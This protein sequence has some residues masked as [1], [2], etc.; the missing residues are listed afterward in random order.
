M[1]NIYK[2][3]KEKIKQG[4]VYKRNLK[5]Y[6]RFRNFTMI[7]QQTYIKNLELAS[8][9]K[10]ISGCVVECGVW[11]G[12]MIAGISQVIGKNRNYYLFDSFQGL[13]PAKE[14]DGQAALS[15][16]KNVESPNYHKNCTASENEAI[17]A[18]KKAKVPS[19]YTRAGWFNKTLPDFRFPEPIGYLRLDADWYESTMI[20]L[21]ELF[22]KVSP[23]GLIVIDDYFTWDGCSRAVHDFL[24]K[25]SLRE[26][27]K[28][29]GDICYIEKSQK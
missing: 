25:H 2:K 19:F 23:R 4:K 12:G 16:Q 28:S 13:P 29:F 11:R 15:W 1:I 17:E 21:E 26:R 6:S 10:N 5:I 8:E 20:C 14:I 27:I 24:S 9:I 7:P 3:I 22:F 18:M